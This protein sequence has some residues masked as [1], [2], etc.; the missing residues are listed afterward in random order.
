MSGQ[1]I[2][3]IDDGWQSIAELNLQLKDSLFFTKHQYRNQTWVIVADKYNENYFRC[4]D[5]AFRLIELLDG[6]RSVDEAYQLLKISS[7]SEQINKEDILLLI[8]NLKSSDLLKD[9][10]NA[11]VDEHI[12][13]E[14]KIKDKQ[15]YQKWMRPFSIKIALFDPGVFLTKTSPWVSYLFKSYILWV[16]LALAVIA[17]ISGWLH[18][19][20][21]TEHWQSRFSD[22]QNILILWIIYPLLKAL[23]E[24]GHAYATKIW[25]GAVHEMGIL[26]LVFFPVP[27]V[28]SSSAHQFQSKYQRALVGAA[29]IMVEIF[30]ASIA[31]IIW[32]NSESVFIKDIAFNI[33]FIGGVSTVLFNGNP[34]LKFDGYYI[35]SDIIEIPNLSTRSSKYLGYLFKRYALAM[36]DC[37]SPVTAVGERKW[38]VFYGISSTI[39]RLFVSLF[40][41]LWIAGKFFIIGILLAIWA[42]IVQ[43]LLPIYSNISKLIPHVISAGKTWRFVAVCSSLILLLAIFLLSPIRHSTYAEGVISLPE[44]ALIRTKASGIIQELYIDNGK[45]VIPGEILIKLENI[46][47]ESELDVLLAKKQ[48]LIVRQNEALQINRAQSD[49]LKDKISIIDIEILDVRTQLLSLNIVSESSGQLSLISAKDLPGRFVEKG[50]VVGYII[51]FSQVNAQIIIPQSNISFV[52]SSTKR[53]EVKLNSNPGESLEA[54]MIRDVPLATNQ[55]PSRVLGT[56]AGGS[57]AVDARDKEGKQSVSNFFKVEIA[58]PM[59]LTGKYLG[60]RVSVRFIHGYESWGEKLLRKTREMIFSKIK[61]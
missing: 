37:I 15:T 10:V 17:L 13:K 43:L 6:S 33:V 44:N 16:W 51:D 48:E 25:G 35:L 41:A 46:S 34:L 4:S 36:N 58:L 56:Q 57:I 14:K 32:V 9:D 22:P 5:V 55:L 52:R 29:G 39:Y 59:K 60:Q 26:F 24:F 31:M 11:D 27:Y 40:I 45:E 8:A 42:I 47:L 1:I 61:G 30:L 53:I 18:S 28:D 19:S 3:K 50:D 2:S 21:L 20:G 23:H 7:D 54:K 49:I 38:F 12:E